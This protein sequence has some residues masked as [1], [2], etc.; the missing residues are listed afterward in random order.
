MQVLQYDPA[1]YVIAN[2]VTLYRRSVQQIDWEGQPNTILYDTNGDPPEVAAL[3]TAQVP[4]QNWKVVGGVVQ[5]LSQADYDAI[6]AQQARWGRSNAFKATAAS[7]S[8]SPTN[9]PDGTLPRSWWVSQD[10]VTN[11][12]I[13]TLPDRWTN[14]WHLTNA[15]ASCPTSNPTGLNGMRTLHFQVGATAQHLE[16]LSYTSSQPHEVFL[17]LKLTPQMDST[18]YVFSSANSGARNDYDYRGATGLIELYAG[19][20]LQRASAFTNTWAVHHVVF[21]GNSSGIY[22][23]NVEQVAGAGGSQ[24]CNGFTLGARHDGASLQTFDF[25]EAITYSSTLTSLQ[26]SNVFFYLTNKFGI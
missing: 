11:S 20:Q 15:V 16:S 13:G 2:R 14:S 9:N 21:N 23:N 19:S 10:Y 7:A 6:A 5:E 26:R 8:W 22:T 24:A 18:R 3:L 12:G 4:M 1:S 25:A 17:M